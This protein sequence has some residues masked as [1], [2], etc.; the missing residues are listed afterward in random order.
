MS[1]QSS[2][3]AHGRE[4]GTRPTVWLLWSLI[5]L[6][7]V[8][9]TLGGYVRLSGSGLA[10]PEWPFFTVSQ[11]L[12]ETGKVIAS[13][14]SIFPPTTEEG[15]VILKDI[16]V[17]DI[18]G[19]EAGIAMSEFKRMFF[20]EW[21]HRAVAKFIG[22][23]YLAFLG[24]ALAYKGVRARIGKLAVINLFV[25]VA[26]AVLGG[27]AVKFHLDSVKVSIHLVNAFIFTSIL[28][29]ML[30]KLLHPA[31]VEKP[32]PGNTILRV[33]SAVYV[34]IMIQL[35]SG[36]LMAASHAGYTMN[37][38]PKMG[39]QWI[40]PGVWEAGTGLYHNLTENV[41]MI[42]LTHRWFA[43]AVALAVLYMALS[44]AYIEVSKVARWALRLAPAI[45]VL[46][47]IL[48]IFTLLKGVHPHLALTHQSVGLV[49]L[50]SVLVVIYETKCH[51]VVSE[52]ALAERE[53]KAAKA[54]QEPAH[55]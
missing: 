23:V 27:L 18:P 13:K 19:F 2:L 6:C 7:F 53:E 8:I 15:W 50:L 22:L 33:S 34:V 39:D 5:V 9:V 48:G 35:F 30:L 47:I 28:S 26:Q 55:A 51:P 43:F 52:A 24:C 3:Q 14:K 49:L 1:T 46:Q 37:T 12:D 17:R 10:I 20:V 45:V 4:P 54:S 25:L 11:T 29:W 36:G 38:W 44:A 31:T 32:S 41:V 16:F 40:A 42:Q 21:S